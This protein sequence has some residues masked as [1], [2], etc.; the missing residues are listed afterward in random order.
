MYQGAAKVPVNELKDETYGSYIGKAS[1][2][3]KKSLEGSKPDI[4][5]WAKR[6]HGIRTAIKKLT[7][8]AGSQDKDWDETQTPFRE[9]QDVSNLDTRSHLHLNKP[10]TKYAPGA[11]GI[12][13]TIHEETKMDNELI[14]EAIEN[15]ME[16]NLVAMKDNLMVALQEKAI[17]KLEERKKD[18]A[19]NYFAQ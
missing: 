18:I 13:H 9:Q 8:E 5:T 4:K 3:R 19:A 15:I 6:E 10:D 12:T 1:K 16:D 17:E 2:S 11:A 7:S 14:N